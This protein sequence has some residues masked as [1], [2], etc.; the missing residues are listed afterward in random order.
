MSTENRYNF[1]CLNCFSS[2]E[3]VNSK[4]K[5]WVFWKINIQKSYWYVDTLFLLLSSFLFYFPRTFTYLENTFNN[6][7]YSLIGKILQVHIK[8]N[9]KIKKLGIRNAETFRVLPQPLLIA[10]ENGT[11]I[12]F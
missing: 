10:E 4:T 9:L 7:K 1:K 6:L 3:I 5:I 8:K 2:W 12:N 11:L